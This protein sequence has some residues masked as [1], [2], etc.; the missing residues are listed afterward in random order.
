MD[1]L[2]FLEHGGERNAIAQLEI[3]KADARV[4]E[5]RNLLELWRAVREETTVDGQRENLRQV[6][7]SFKITVPT[8]DNSSPYLVSGRTSE[9]FVERVSALRAWEA[10]R[11]RGGSSSA[12]AAPVF[13]GPPR[14]GDS[15]AAEL[16]GG[17]EG[18]AP[19][20]QKF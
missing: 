7:R 14:G 3:S 18:G 19:G 6:A 1:V 12:S 4:D 16:A 17:G 20:R 9:A 10:V 8:E 5:L 2:G 15:D 11:N 13:P